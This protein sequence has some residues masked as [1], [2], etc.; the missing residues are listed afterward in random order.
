MLHRRPHL[1][2]L[3]R[4]HRS[5]PFTR[6]SP[7]AVRMAMA[8]PM[9]VSVAAVPVPKPLMRQKVHNDQHPAPP[10][11]L[12]QAPRGTHR[13]LEVVKPQPDDGEVEVPEAGPREGG[14]AR[15]RGGEE[16]TSIRIHLVRGEALVRRRGVVLGDHGRGQVDARGA[17]GELAQ[18][19]GHVAG[20]AGIVQDAEA[21]RRRVRSLVRGVRAGIFEERRVDEGAVGLQAGDEVGAG[22]LVLGVVVRGLAPA[23]VSFRGGPLSTNQ[24]HFTVTLK[25]VRWKMNWWMEN[26]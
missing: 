12:G 1:G 4:D 13:V 5:L 3:L 17:A 10:Q 21:G 15:V 18:G 11:P 23:C 25:V 26:K 22:L 14:R 9:P 8:M 6:L 24:A 16:I 20:A 19:L 7:P 2:L